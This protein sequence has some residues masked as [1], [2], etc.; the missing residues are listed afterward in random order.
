MKHRGLYLAWIIAC[1]G[2][3]GSLFLGEFQDREPCPLCWY[4]RI[5]LF[6]LVIILGIAAIRHAHRIILY[7]LPLSLIGLILAIYQVA[8]LNLGL[9]CK[10][11][12]I[13]EVSTPLYFPLLSLIE[14]AL[15]TVILIWTMK[16]N[17]N[18]KKL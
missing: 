14:F 5:L 8:A 11:C 7:V 12:K 17:R 15:L 10:S 2:T 16:L 3:I 4:Q 9:A 18:S 13:S 6:P 1:I